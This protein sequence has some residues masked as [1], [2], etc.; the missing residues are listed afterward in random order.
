MSVVPVILCGGGGTRLWPASTPGRPKGLMS[1]A[2]RSLLTATLDRC[3]GL[4]DAPAVIV[5]PAEHEAAVRTLLEAGPDPF[6]LLLETSPRDTAAA[7]LAGARL[8]AAGDPQTVVALLP[9]DHHVGDA[10]AFR[11]A[12]REAADLAREGRLVLLGVVPDAPSSAYGH[13]RPAGA[14]AAPVAAFVE[15]P[16]LET[17]A[18]LMTEGCLWNA[19]ILVARADVLQAE[20]ERHAP[21][22]ARAVAAAVTG[23]GRLGPS[24]ADAPRISMDYAVLE[25]TDRAWVLPV[26]FG[27]SDLGA[28]DAVA[29]HAPSAAARLVDADRVWVQAPDGVQVAVVGLSD[30]IVVVE[31]GAVLVC[32]RDAAQQ[33][34]RAATS[35]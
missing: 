10:G 16:D 32:A 30:V 6:D 25:K 13:I 9:C 24:F 29:D 2:G 4:S 12:L 19:G 34:R 15:K 20:A 21:E 23:P 28:W 8:A 35:D 17:A 22:V 18:R 7:M 1:V 31:D 11:A 33:V 27:W 5:A 26:D 14:G 3:R